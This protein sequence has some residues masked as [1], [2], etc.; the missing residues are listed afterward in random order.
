MVTVDVIY[1]NKTK[2]VDYSW[3]HYG[4]NVFHLA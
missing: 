1:C 4:C 3:Q 2:N